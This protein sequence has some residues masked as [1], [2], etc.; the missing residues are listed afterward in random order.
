MS[1]LNLDNANDENGEYVIHSKSEDGFWSNEDGWVDDIDS[2]TVFEAHEAA[3]STKPMS[4]ETDAIWVGFGD[5]NFIKSASQIRIRGIVDID[6]KDTGLSIEALTQSVACFLGEALGMDE[7]RVRNKI[8]PDV[9]SYCASHVPHEAM[10]LDEDDISEWLSLQ[11]QDG[12]MGINDL[13]KLVSRAA[14]AEPDVICAEF[15][16]RMGLLTP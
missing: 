16:E 4:A 5:A 12:S 8:D 14:I 11:V 3:V 9:V 1:A 7:L 6:F 13:I 2:A 15:A 10:S